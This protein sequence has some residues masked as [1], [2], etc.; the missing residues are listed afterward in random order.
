MSAPENRVRIGVRGAMEQGSQLRPSP[1]PIG[2]LHARIALREAVPV[3]CTAGDVGQQLVHSFIQFFVGVI[4]HLQ[5]I[6]TVRP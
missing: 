2:A 3:V 5:L 1:M 4:G 6:F